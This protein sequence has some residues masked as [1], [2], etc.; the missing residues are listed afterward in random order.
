MSRSVGWLAA[1]A[2]IAAGGLVVAGGVAL[3]ER[4]VAAQA[5]S[6]KKA[7]VLPDR[8]RLRGLKRAVDERLTYIPGRLL[9]KF[10]E[11][12]SLTAKS[13]SLSRVRGAHLTAGEAYADFDIVEIAADVDPSAAAASLATQP[14]IE[15]AEPDGLRF[16]SFRPNDPSYNRQWNMPAINMETAWDINQGGDSDL[17]VAVLDSG[18]AYKTDVYP[19]R[20]FDGSVVRT[21][22]VP[23]AAAPDLVTANRFVSPFDFIWGD[24][25]PV[26]FDGHGTHVAGTIAQT[27]NNNSGL[28]GVAFNVRLMPVKVC[29]SAWDILFIFAD[30]G[31]V[32]V[33]PDFSACPDS[34]VSQGIRWAADHGAKVINMSF[35]GP[36]TQSRAVGDALR[37][38]V[39]RGVF[40]SIAAGNEFEEGNPVSHPA[41]F[42]PEIA[43][44]VT[45][46]AVGRNQQ[47]APYSNT[48]PYLELAAPG[49]N[50]RDGGADGMIL[51]QTLNPSFFDVILVSPRFDVFREAAF[52]GTSMAS[53]HVAGLAA[54]L[55]SQGVT[56]P[57]AIEAA[58]RQFARD[59]GPAGLD[60]EYGSG[61][62]DARAT[63]RGLG[64]LR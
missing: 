43:G 9:V 10:E 27:T 17:I 62:I 37:Y 41:S 7:G 22:Q 13:S 39:G 24:D 47:R 6:G 44:V 30:D 64:L 50:S 38:A 63:L 26:D 34:E 45:V 1:C 53:P 8:T 20:R 46:G 52:Q 33:D 40:I 57:V 2:A 49:G 21:V 60:E 58:L 59:L 31:V 56:S 48:G 3:G 42:A 36:G 12:L 25:E 61:L 19:L 54:L 18:I 51:Q 4:R 55:M 15:Y 32:L 14:G 28:S 16:V 29:A 23:V 11:G 35:G 5:L